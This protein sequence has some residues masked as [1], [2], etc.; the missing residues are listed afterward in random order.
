LLKKTKV[1]FRGVAIRWCC[2]LFVGV[3]LLSPSLPYAQ[4]QELISD[5]KG[6]VVSASV[7]ASRAGATILAAGG[8]AVDAAVAT[9]FALAVTEPYHS[10]IGGGGFL[11]LRRADGEVIALDGREEAPEAAV[12]EMFVIPGVPEDASRLGGLSVGVPG[13]V[14]MLADALEA[15]GT[16][17]LAE[18]MAPAIELA[19][20]GVAIGP[21]HADVLTRWKVA[22]L[23]QR[24]PE[25]AR[26]QL[27]PDGAPIRP[28]WRL[29][30]KDLAGTLRQ[31]AS[32]GKSAFYEGPI[33]QAIVVEARRQGGIL[34]LE[35]LADYRAKRRV[36]IHGTY[37]GFDV[38]S[39]PPPS[40][41]GIVLVGTLNV[42]EG[43]DLSA[44]GAGSL[45]SVHLAAEAMKLAFADR[46]AYLGDSDFVDVPVSGL[47]SKQYAKTQ[48]A[49]I[50]LPW[51]RRAPWTWG[52]APRA[53]VVEQAGV[54]PSD[55]GT[56]HFSIA[57]AQ[58]NAVAVTQTINLHFGSGI[59]VPGTGI[60]LNDEMDD[61]AKAPNAPN[62]FG[63]VD[64]RGSNAIAP[65]KRPLSSMSPTI[66]SREGQLF[67]VTGSP[68]GSRIISTTLLTILNAVD[69]GMNA[70]EVVSAPRFHHQWVPDE[71]L[72]E[73]E[74]PTGLIEGLEARGHHVQ[75][76]KQPWSS[77][78]V[79]L[80]D[81]VQGVFTGGSDPRSDG[82]AVGPSSI[83]P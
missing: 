66:L 29:V 1:G 10:G 63:L 70:Q 78:Q 75:I 40:S 83:V 25:T 57:D 82:A 62:A 24:F 45:E 27:P 61:F 14:A 64:T 38:D 52:R 33:A 73:P 42:L 43:F 67:M 81:P 15:Y 12:R 50:A 26:I 68:G 18:V 48:R 56:S 5:S 3:L 37:R 8:N 21:Y 31:I 53:S 20:Q 22:G 35:D 41:G 16:L 74:T 46:A 13:L 6:L 54:P 30:Q 36:P 19:E 55:G 60:V 4:P 11:L 23:A 49:R 58:G 69:F 80:F 39:F 59:T 65:G 9:S 28:G 17:S 79:I 72:V 71:L 51:F 77:A 34:S 32:E 76:S 47:I 7:E 2:T 44:H